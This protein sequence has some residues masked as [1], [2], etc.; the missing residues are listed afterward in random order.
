MA[1]ILIASDH[2][3]FHLKE[4]LKKLYNKNQN[5]DLEIL[6]KIDLEQL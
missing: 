1:K 6:M 3:G 5:I 4:E 2:A